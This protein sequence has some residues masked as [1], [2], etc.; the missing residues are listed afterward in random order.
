MPSISPSPSAESTSPSSA[1]STNLDPERLV[2]AYEAADLLGV[3]VPTVKEWFRK[4]YLKLAGKRQPP[5]RG[6]PLN[7]YRLGDIQALQP[8]CRTKH[9][10]KP[11]YEAWPPLISAND[12][13]CLEARREMWVRENRSWPKFPLARRKRAG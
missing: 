2:S 12:Y 5:L 7:V 11:K 3:P 4:R 9:R 8:R 10:R 1:S 13:E 6:N